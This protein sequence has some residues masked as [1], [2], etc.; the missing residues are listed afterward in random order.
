MVFFICFVPILSTKLVDIS[1]S[2][3]VNECLVPGQALSMRYTAAYVSVFCS[4][5]ITDVVGV[6]EFLEHV[7]STESYFNNR[8]L[9]NLYHEVNKKVDSNSENY[10][11]N[12]L[13]PTELIFCNFLVWYTV[14]NG[15]GIRFCNYYR[16]KQMINEIFWMLMRAHSLTILYSSLYE[17]SKLGQSIVSR[18]FDGV[19]LKI[20]KFFFSKHG[21][22]CNFYGVLLLAF[23][24]LFV[25]SKH[26]TDRRRAVYVSPL[27]C[28]NIWFS[29][30]Q[31]F[32]IMLDS[33][34]LKG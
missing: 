10:Q 11:Y 24:Q 16:T 27:P 28:Q 30:V 33:L 12:F 26:I 18:S 3:R 25:R 21:P 22:V 23:F 1:A 5:D 8:Y 31:A 14:E 32:M 17:E 15:N 29:D 20:H 34:I 19:L 4:N 9:A 2:S 6:K 7:M 13:Y